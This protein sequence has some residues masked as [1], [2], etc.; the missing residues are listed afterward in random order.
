MTLYANIPRLQSVW[1]KESL[2]DGIQ[3]TTSSDLLMTQLSDET[4]KSPNQT[5]TELS[6][7]SPVNSTLRR[8]RKDDRKLATS[9][10][11]RVANGDIYACTEC[12]KTYSTSSN[13][14][15]HQQTHRSSNDTKARKCPQCNKVYVSMP[16]YSMHLQTHTQ[17][18]VC[19]TCGKSFSRPW[20]LQGHLRIHTGEKPYKC[21]RCSKSFADKSN[22]R[23]H[24]QIHSAKKP[25]QCKHCGKCFALNSYLHKHKE[26]TCH[27]LK[28][29]KAVEI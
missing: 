20:R 23:A 8:Q 11:T 26:A 10:E 3:L 22:L 19:K 6:S 25:F 17:C 27:R 15:R 5:D 14:A 18:Y 7:T 1:Q 12:W 13:L 28:K 21:S 9:E 24:E 2:P 16:A 29:K 4:T